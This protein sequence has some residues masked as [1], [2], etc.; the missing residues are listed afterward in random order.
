MKIQLMKRTRIILAIL[1]IVS[2]SYSNAQQLT[3]IKKKAGAPGKIKEVYQ[4]LSSDNLV[5]QGKYKRFKR[6]KLIEEGFY[7]NNMKDSTWKIYSIDHGLIAE[8]NYKD[9][10]KAGTWLYY[11]KQKELVQKCDHSLDSLLYINKAFL[12]VSK[13][14]DSLNEVLPIFIGGMD[15]MHTI[16]ENNMVYPDAAFELNKSGVVYISFVVDQH[17]SMTDIKSIKPAGNGFDEEALRLMNS[18]GRSWIPGRSK[19]KPVRVQYT[20]PLRFTLK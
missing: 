14:N 15:Y 19:G 11:S 18:F 8:G 9:D 16:I 10:R 20:I 2:A 6:K 13:G 5:K 12:P 7:K 17:G 4:V 1:L 3:T